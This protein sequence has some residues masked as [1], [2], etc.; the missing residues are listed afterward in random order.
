MSGLSIIHASD[1]HLGSSGGPERSSVAAAAWERFTQAVTE[2]EPD[3]VV[4]SGDLVVDDPDDERDQRAAHELIT[5]LVAPVLVVPGNHD[6]GDHRVR[7][8]LPADWHGK[9]V[10][11]ARVAAWE[12]RWGDS[13]GITEIGGWSILALNSQLLGS[14]LQREA[15]QW[16]WI[17]RTAL[18]AIGE[19]PF[20]LVMHESLDLRPDA[21]VTD[22]WMSIPTNPSAELVG[23][24]SGR[25][26]VAV[27]S[28]HTHRYL[29]WWSD[30]IRN[31][32]APSL[33]GPIPVRADMSQAAGDP[34]PGW[35]SYSLRG[36][37]QLTIVPHTLT[38]Q[39]F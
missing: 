3:L 7:A 36:P 29:D 9:L 20:L 28:G 12:R 27:C 10:T 37:D 24:L 25:N 34:S 8:G 30:G 32:T 5:G 4:V 11:D 15:E 16:S 35:L 6:V 23:L 22:S 19:R 38:A 17:E 33:A 39:T 21:H 31:I 1:P 13:F 14:G 2:A 26:L 18:P